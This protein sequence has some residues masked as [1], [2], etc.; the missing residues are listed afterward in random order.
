MS[1]VLTAI[2]KQ[3]NARRSILNGKA[4]IYSFRCS[5]SLFLASWSAHEQPPLRNKWC[6]CTAEDV[7]TED[8]RNFV[9][10][11]AET[12][13]TEIGKYLRVK[14]VQDPWP[15]SKTCFSRKEHRHEDAV[16]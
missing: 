8:W 5:W 4:I 2:A 3:T 13:G 11:A 14:P 1:N 16:I 7:I 15:H 12:Y 9:I 10:E 6:L